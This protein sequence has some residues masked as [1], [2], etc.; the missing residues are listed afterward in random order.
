MV[1][2]RAFL[3]GTL[4]AATV[5]FVAACQRRL[6]KPPECG[7]YIGPPKLAVIDAHCHIFNGSDLQVAGFINQV[8]LGLP[9]RSLLNVIGDLVQ[10]WA[11]RYAPTATDE[12][13][14]LRNRSG[15][16][17][18]GPGL[19]RASLGTPA[20]GAMVKDMGVDTDERFVAFWRDLAQNKSGQAAEFSNR[21]ARYRNARLKS[22]SALQGQLVLSQLQSAQ[23]VAQFIEEEQQY[24]EGGL[25]IVTFLK[26]FFR[27]RTENAWSMMWSYGCGSTPGVDLLCPAM[28]DFDLW[29][30]DRNYDEGRTRSHIEGQLEVMRAISLATQGRVHAMVPFNPLRAACD[31]GDNVVAYVRDAV[32]K[33][34]CLGFKLYPP[35]G[36]AATGNTPLPYPVPR[37]PGNQPVA[38]DRKRLDEVLGVFF[39]EC[40]ALG[41][42]VMA[43]ASPS[44]ASMDGTETLASPTFWRGLMG[45]HA[46]AFLEGSS[47]VRIS[48]GH[49]GGDH[50]VQHPS[51]W[52]EDIVEMMAE[53]P[54]RVYA[55]LSYYDHILGSASTRE[56]LAEQLVSL[57][58]PHAL[59][60]VMYG[61][62]WSMLAA[63]SN[64]H[65][66]LNAFASFLATEMDLE[67]AERQDILGR[68][69][70]R[71]FD[72]GPQ[73][74]G[75]E[76]LQRFHDRNGGWLFRDS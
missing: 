9:D 39:D 59:R 32:N 3:H 24:G 18:V 70:M 53:Y 76:R 55:D 25:A 22:V 72:L 58:Q 63:V 45:T 29:L 68:N 13:N 48:L 37:C 5:A 64:A 36:F 30:G 4:A 50:D 2:R 15:P 47:R 28:V 8:K 7:H 42:P 43:H 54:D 6:I 46:T 57:K 60:H 20:L 49:M 56:R 40:S 71:F 51:D 10:S 31:G 33:Y 66:Y 38:V 65:N 62:D 67:S 11:W 34:G 12:L 73:G 1:N 35:M 61:S 23:G 69:A 26:T 52:R 74:A 16:R 27:F 14:W 17:E 44:N 41:I 19:S 75:R 21:L